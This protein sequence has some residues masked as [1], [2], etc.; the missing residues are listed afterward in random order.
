M[1][2]A[3]HLR[4]VDVAAGVMR[5]CEFHPRQFQGKFFGTLWQ[6]QHY[7]HQMNTI[8]VSVKF[9]HFVYDLN[10]QIIFYCNSQ[11]MVVASSVRKL[12]TVYRYMTHN[13]VQTLH[14][15]YLDS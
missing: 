6:H 8:A 9:R 11:I 13:C 5:N 15:G 10:K 1:S 3:N 14:E 2:I 4:H 7:Q 12:A